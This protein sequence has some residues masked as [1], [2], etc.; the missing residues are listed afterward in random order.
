MAPRPGLE[1]KDRN[2]PLA[3]PLPKVLWLWGA[4]VPVKRGLF[5][6]TGHGAGLSL[7]LRPLGEGGGHAECGVAGLP[8][9]SG[10]VRRHH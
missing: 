6:M 8:E 1:S 3:L 7:H 10:W 2:A 4:R 9:V 5:P